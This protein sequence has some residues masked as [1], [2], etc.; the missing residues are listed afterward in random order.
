MVAKRGF[1]R[2]VPQKTVRILKCGVS[3]VMTH[4]WELR[5]LGGEISEL[6]GRVEMR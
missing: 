6:R 2:S 3:V 4:Q 5:E 1:A